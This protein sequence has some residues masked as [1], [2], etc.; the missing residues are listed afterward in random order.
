MEKT[1]IDKIKER[2]DMTEQHPMVYLDDVEEIVGDYFK[3]HL[4]PYDVTIGAVMFSK[5][6]KLETFINAARQYHDSLMRR[7]ESDTERGIR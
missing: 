6:I 1:L 2:C 7:F 3:Q 5:G 4:L